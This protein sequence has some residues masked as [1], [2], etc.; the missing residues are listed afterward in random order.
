M[1]MH[2]KIVLNIVLC[3]CAALLPLGVLADSSTTSDDIVARG[4]Y[5]ARAGNCMGCHTARGGADF[6]GGRRL[7]SDFGIF[8]T[9]NLTPD[10]DSGIGNWTKEQFW[11]AMHHGQRP[12]G[13][14]MYP[15]CPYP[16]FTH[17]ERNDTDAIYTYLHSLPAVQQDNP[18]HDLSFPASIRSVM[19][20]WQS[21]FFDPGTFEPD[22]SESASWNRGAY[23]VQGLGHCMTCHTQRNRLGATLEDDDVAGAHVSGW[24]APSLH[25]SAEAG[26]QLWS[27]D[28]SVQ[29]LRAGKSGDASMLGPMADVVYNSLQ[30]LTEEDVRA[31]TDY[32]R[33]LPDR[34]ISSSTRQP[35]IAP[36]RLE[37]V[38]VRGQEIYESNCMDCHGDA[39][40]GTVAAS[41]LVGNR[42]VT[43]ADP[44]NVIN[45][46]RHGGYPPSTRGNPRPFGMPPFYD[47]S[48]AD[49]AAVA[50]YIRRNWGNEGTPVP[51]VAVERTR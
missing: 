38:M 39:G 23:L 48:A 7:T 10:R 22:P 50:T 29:L 34:E 31:M 2:V 20:I 18:E 11:Q 14:P 28:K 26:L 6:A 51:T 17:I 40:Q 1:I 9:P 13:S 45:V 15:A 5:L 46:I 35:Q 3:A 12:D 25:S 49:V 4:E 27:P 36:E 43:L 30:Y 41:A 16:S 21:L 32:L 19:S 33:S 47:L 42:A 24:Y 8:Y 37:S 44:T